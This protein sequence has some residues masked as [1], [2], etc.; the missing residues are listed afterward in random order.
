MIRREGRELNT[1]RK[2]LSESHVFFLNMKVIEIFLN[3]TWFFFLE[4]QKK[5]KK[6]CWAEQDE[7]EILWIL[8]IFAITANT[9]HK[10]IALQS[11]SIRQTYLRYYLSSMHFFISFFLIVE[12][13]NTSYASKYF[14]KIYR[15]CSDDFFFSF[16]FLTNPFMLQYSAY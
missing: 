12:H 3:G 2:L 5:R 16:C 4:Y 11:L 15:I 13:L 1:E 7:F 14:H 9:K 6:S 10:N 8:F